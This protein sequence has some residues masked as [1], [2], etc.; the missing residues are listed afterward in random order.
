MKKAQALDR[1]ARLLKS[2]PPTPLPEKYRVRITVEPLDDTGA[3]LTATLDEVTRETIPDP[4][5]R[6][7][8]IAALVRDLD[9]FV[10]HQG[11]APDKETS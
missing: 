7:D 3:S 8:G 4:D 10:Y 5:Y 11:P 2:A 1:L 6:N 9:Y